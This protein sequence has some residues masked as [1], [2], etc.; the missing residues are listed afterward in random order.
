MPLTHVTLSILKIGNYL[1]I[2]NQT[3]KNQGEKK[4]KKKKKKTGTLLKLESCELIPYIA[5]LAGLF[6]FLG[7]NNKRKSR[8]GFWSPNK[9]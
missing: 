2:C 4:K 1:Q 5:D 9:L 7:V 3:M 8:L 6:I